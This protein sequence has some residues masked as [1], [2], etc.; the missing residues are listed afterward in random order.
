MPYKNWLL[1]RQLTDIIDFSDHEIKE[2][3]NLVN[4]HA[5]PWLEELQICL[6]SLSVM[7][8]KDVDFGRSF[9]LVAF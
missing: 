5:L 4:N 7:K 9:A 1:N 3:K 8:P 6:N 2:S